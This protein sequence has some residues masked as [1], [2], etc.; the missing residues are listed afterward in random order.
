MEEI[1]GYHQEIKTISCNNSKECFDEQVN[2]YLA[3]GWGVVTVKIIKLTNDIA[4][5]AVLSKWKEE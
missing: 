5:F 3:K 2:E 4:Y 1:K